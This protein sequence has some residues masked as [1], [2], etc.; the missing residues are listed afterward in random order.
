[1]D[2]EQEARAKPTN[3]QFP[4]Q[5]NH[6]QF[7]QIRRRSLER[8]ID[9]R[10]LGESALGRVAAFHV[11][12]GA[13]ASEEGAHKT[14]AADLVERSVDEGSDPLVA[15]EVTVNIMAGL[16]L[17][18][19]ELGGETERRDA[20]DDAEVDGFGAAAGLFVELVDG[21]AGRLTIPV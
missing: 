6:R 17:G 2:L 10:A 13:H 12:N 3:F 1:M 15:L 5:R 7:D 18:N 20:I 14:I 21:D 8:G 16:V 11:W 4:I 19:A 9:G